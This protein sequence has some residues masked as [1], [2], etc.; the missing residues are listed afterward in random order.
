MHKD[1]SSYEISGSKNMQCC[2]DENDNLCQNSGLSR[3]QAI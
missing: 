1:S 2:T 3:E